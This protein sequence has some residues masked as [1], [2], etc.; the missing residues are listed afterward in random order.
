MNSTAQATRDASSLSTHPKWEERG[1]EWTHISLEESGHTSLLEER[2]D[3]HL[4]EGKGAREAL[5]PKTVQVI[6]QPSQHPPQ[7]Q[8]RAKSP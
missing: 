6:E 1:G 4:S 7:P 2:V 3:T 8:I 5:L